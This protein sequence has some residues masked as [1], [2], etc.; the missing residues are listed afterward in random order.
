MKHLLS[1]AGSRELSPTNRPRQRQLQRRTMVLPGLSQQLTGQGALALLEVLLF[2]ATMLR[3]EVAMSCQVCQTGVKL[4][5]PY[6]V[7]S[8]SLVLTC[9]VAYA[10]TLL[11]GVHL[12]LGECIS[13]HSLDLP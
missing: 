3:V 1:R 2:P 5:K 6:D 10:V 7:E 12:P 11:P 4:Y 8:R 9:L 13:H